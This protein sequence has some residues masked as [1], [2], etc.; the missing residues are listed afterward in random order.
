[1]SIVAECPHC[2]TRFHL[3]PDLVGKTIRCPNVECRQ[4][5]TVKPAAPKPAKGS[6]PARPNQA[7]GQVDDML[8]VLEV[9]K[10][11]PRPKPPEPEVVEAKIVAPPARQKPPKAKPVVVDAAVVAPPAKEVV[12]SADADAPGGPPRR[13]AEEALSL[14]DDHHDEDHH[15][16]DD[17]PI[18]RRRRK[19][20]G[21]KGLFIG[22]GLAVLAVG[23]AV[24]GIQQLGRVDKLSEEKVAQQADEDYKKGDYPAAQKAFRKLADDF[25]DSPDINRYKFYAELSGVQAAAR[26]SSNRDDPRPAVRSI[27]EFL[28]A[29]KNSPHMKAPGT[30]TKEVLD[31]GGKLGDDV[32]ARVKQRIEAKDYRGAEDAIAAGKEL[33][34]VL[35]TLTDPKLP[36]LSTITANL[37]AAGGDI[38]RATARIDALEHARKLLVNAPE[39]VIERVGGDLQAAGLAADPEAQAIIKD[40][41]AN[42]VKLAK[43]EPDPAKPETPPATAAASLLFV[44]SVGETKAPGKGDSAVFLCLARGVVYAIDEGGNLLW[45]A[46]VGADTRDVPTVART[47]ADGPLDVALVVSNLAGRPALTAHDLKTGKPLWT[48]SLYA[49]QSDRTAPAAG[50]AVV[51]GSR[52]FV[53][54][55][56]SAAAGSQDPEGAVI[57]YDLASGDRVGRVSFG[58]PVGPAAVRPGTGLVYVTADSRRVYV[59][60]AGADEALGRRD[61]RCVQALPTGH[62]PGTIRTP[63]L[64]VGPE[65]DGPAE[66]PRLMLLTQADGPTAT[67]LRAFTLPPSL[68]GGESAPPAEVPVSTETEQRLKGWTWFPLATDGETLTAVTDAG[69]ARLFGLNQPGNTDRAIFPQPSPELPPVPDG[70]PV[71]GLA[72]PAPDGAVWVLANGELRRFRLTLNPMKGREA[73]ATGPAVRL[74]VPTQPAQLNATRDVACLVVR[75]AGSSGVRAVALDLKTGAVRWKRQL[76]VVAASAPLRTGDALTLADQDGGVVVIPADGTNVPP[77]TLH[78]APPEWVTPAADEPAGP[79]VVAASDDGKAVYTVTPAKPNNLVIRRLAD[80]KVTRT[81]NLPAKGGLLGTPAVV[82][83]RL[84]LPLADGVVYRLEVSPAGAQSD[85]LVPGPPWKADNREPDAAGVVVPLSDT[86]FVTG[87][88][89]RRLAKWDWPAGPKWLPAGVMWDIRERVAIPPLYLPK[90]GAGAPPRLLVADVTGSVWLYPADK[91]GPPKRWQPG[92][93]MPAG[94]P[95]GRFAL[96]TDPAG[97]QLVAFAVEGKD[98]A[99]G[100][101]VVGLEPATDAILWAVKPADG[102]GGMPVGP[103]QPADGGRWLVTSLSGRVMAVDAA[104]GKVAASGSVGLPGAVPA[105]AG[106]AAGAGRVLCPLSDGSA[107]VVTLPAAKE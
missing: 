43:Y 40:A 4:T 64:F 19:K 61:P 5:F 44:A 88:G 71:P 49:R 12:W 33:V 91:V 75:S 103:P 58:Q 37:D 79:T 23:L 82:G 106:V 18:V 99:E 87:D 55:R 1:V 105:A 42:V 7:S 10:P 57:V 15:D 69:Q 26:A 63:P 89:G 94:R 28:D 50:P 74:G 22:V 36:P 6:A 2:E 51:V 95:V 34:D 101:T 73:T 100:Y 30:G 90:S 85:T 104:T 14:D 27:R 70:V 60:D 77:G 59:L 20:K 31:A 80:G 56:E 102:A 84:L 54:L 24:F 47:A 97:R 72:I 98:A 32:V 68:A 17:E 35:G 66:L 8:P 67:K 65:G 13:P 93:L 29:H 3:Q 52:V 62:L 53:P 48:Q 45:A 9:D 107:V 92:G 96:Q 11:K 21:K 25:P 83:D 41:W 39:S 46:R 38:G 78:P 76:G 81:S 16:H 86:A